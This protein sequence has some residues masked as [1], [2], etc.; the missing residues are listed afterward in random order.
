MLKVVKCYSQQLPDTAPLLHY[1]IV[2]CN[3]IKQFDTVNS[4]IMCDEL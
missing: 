4:T 3:N 2:D 1:P